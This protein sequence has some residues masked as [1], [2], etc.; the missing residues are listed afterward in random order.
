MTQF[1]TRYESLNV[2]QREAVDC[3]DGPLLV[4]AGPGTGKTELL[5][6]RA[7]NILRKTDTLPENILCLTFTD[8]G[9]SAMRERLSTIIGGDAYRIAIHTF[10]SFGTEIQSLY[11]EFF[12]R[13]ATFKPADDLSTHEI[14]SGIFGELDHGNILASTMSGTYTYLSDARQSMSELKQAGLTSDELLTVL[15][16]NEAALD[17]VEPELSRIFS[18]RISSTTLTLMAPLAEKLASM[19]ATPLPL[20]ITPL[21]N[22]LALSMAHAFDEAVESGKT[23]P[24]TAWRNRWMEKNSVGD[25][26]FKDRKRSQKLRA[27]SH[28]YYSYLTRMEQ[29][30]LFDYDDM[31]LNTVHAMESEPELKA[32]L[33]E[34][35]QYIMVDEFQDTNLAQ[36][37]ILFNLTD[38]PANEGRPNLM[39]VGDDDQAIYSFQGADAG[40]IRSFRERFTDTSIIALTDN[41]RST[42]AIL[43]HARE[44][45]T[46]G[47]GRLESVI[48]SLDKT[49]VPHRSTPANSVRF[50]EY[51]TTQDERSGIARDIAATIAS[52]TAPESI[53]II[54]RTHR[55]L[56]E[57][58]PYLSHEQLAVNYEKRDNVLTHESVEAVELLAEIITSLHEGRHDIADA[59]LPEL[60][61]H[62]AFAVSAE[63]LWRISL[64]AYRNHQ[65][66]L[67]VM[68]TT[69]HLITVRSWLISLAKDAPHIAL[70]PMLDLLIGTPESYATDTFCS[71]FYAYY[72]APEK[73]AENPTAYLSTLE[74]LRTIRTHLREYRPNDELHLIDF[75]EFI[76]LHDEI[77][78]TLTSVRS[79]GTNVAH[80][81]N[82]LTAHKSKG[83]EFDHV[84]I[85][86]AVDTTWGEKVR[87]RSRLIS[88]PENL[89][90]T[91]TTNDYDER[92]RLFFVSM[93]RARRHLTITHAETDER[94]KSLLPARFLI[95]TT[96]KVAK[97]PARVSVQELTEIARI[98][99]HDYAAAPITQPM[100]DLLAPQLERYKLSATHLN[101]FIDI[102]RGG[103]QTF[104]LTNLLRFPQAKSPHASYGTAMHATLQ[105]AHVY[106]TRHGSRRPVE[107]VLGDFI[108]ELTAQHLPPDDFTHFSR[109]GADALTAFLNHSYDTF[110]P[111]QKTELNLAGQGVVVEEAR[112]TGA[113]DLVDITDGT[114]TVIDYKTG[115]PSNTWK[116]S[117]DSE[118]IKLHKYRQQLMFYQLLIEHS[119]DYHTYQFER[120]VL[121]FVEPSRDGHIY[122]LEATFTTNEL[123]QF[124]ALIRGIWRCITSL[125]LPETAE[126]D[127]NYKGI[128][129]F[130]QHIIDKYA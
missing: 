21:A 13:G 27:L 82:L 25:F 39:A 15:R 18:A 121:Q 65:T 38:S 91:P 79:P 5:S 110:L 33:Q 28:I 122:Q 89:H 6:M 72:F 111:H 24:V 129:K 103:P 74:A 87:S 53:A 35:Y 105:R 42:P 77:G 96:L 32:T 78:T 29:A 37:R 43:T 80:A 51:S 113:L 4:I 128:L 17:L 94:G 56:V 54:A 19:P 64:Q 34:K 90:I 112:L 59:L 44:V 62:P 126:F 86:G 8:S 114:I 50:M 67:E 36:L 31:I 95:D 52:G 127:A 125:E 40:N 14:L 69:P 109:R 124:R 22:T 66:W 63:D 92:V 45:I 12:Y 55:E 99:W 70:E 9:A 73:L 115:R 60:L 49:L 20:G 85:T 97:Q 108:N 11:R 93:T 130:E 102:T 106:L 76:Q 71:P 107:D 118:K 101:N 75:L 3:I 68:A 98:D 7:A 58:L 123:E 88:Y 104:L 46:Q 120:G 1:D 26:V 81:I 100:R 117:S 83:L 23:T 116:G 41:Y 48:E 30:R 84:Y 47:G 119:R 2:R 57:L 61:S 10:H 16:A